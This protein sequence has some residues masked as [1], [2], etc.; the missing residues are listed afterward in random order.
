MDSTQRTARLAGFFYFIVV[1]TGIY[2]LMYI[3]KTFIVWS[4]PALTIQKI[5]ADIFLFKTGI[6]ASVICYVAFLLLPLVLYKLLEHINKTQGVAMVALAVASVPISLFNLSNRMAVVTV[7]ENA[8]HK[9]SVELQDQLF[10]YLRFYNNGIDI[11]TVFWGL[12]LIPFG[13]LVFRSGF[14]PKVLGLLL[15]TGG[16]ADVIHLGADFLF[17][18]YGTMGIGSWVT[19]PASMGEIGICLWLLIMGVKKNSI[20]KT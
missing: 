7:L 14:L 17:P 18:A 11:V 1:L 12:W 16:I 13:L 15:V 20:P 5:Q 3:P 10:L 4:D 9:T 19:L 6:V 8:A 2:S